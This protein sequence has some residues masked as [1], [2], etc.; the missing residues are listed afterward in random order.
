MLRHPSAAS[1]APAVDVAQRDVDRDLRAAAHDRVPVDRPAQLPLDEGADDLRAE[2][3]P[4]LTLGEA[5][6]GVAHTDLEALL[7][8]LGGDLHVALLPGES[9]LD[10]IG[11]EL[12]QGEG[13]GCRVFAGKRPEP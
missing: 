8:A 3:A 10:R 1:A 9:V 4:D 5:G 2:T 13:E 7:T 6:A 12:G 11:H